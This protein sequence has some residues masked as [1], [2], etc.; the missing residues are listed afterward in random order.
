V[1]NFETHSPDS[2]IISPSK[3][4]CPNSHIDSIKLIRLLSKAPWKSVS[5]PEKC[6][7][8]IYRIQTIKKSDTS[9]HG[10]GLTISVSLRKPVYKNKLRLLSKLAFESSTIQNIVIHH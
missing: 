1:G 4:T 3:K 7:S 6:R 5:S 8:H 10:I 9:Q 2:A